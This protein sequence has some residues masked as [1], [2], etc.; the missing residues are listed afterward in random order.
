M[1]DPTP[2]RIWLI[3]DYH[4]QDGTPV[5]VDWA[6]VKQYDTDIPYVRADEIE[7]R[8]EALEEIDRHIRAVSWRKPGAA[9]RYGSMSALR[10]KKIDEIV[11]AILPTDD[12]RDRVGTK[13]VDGG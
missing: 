13:G 2:V 7:R 8:A 6:D 11:R 3:L 12:S 10:V 5:Y 4:L 9:P 1:S